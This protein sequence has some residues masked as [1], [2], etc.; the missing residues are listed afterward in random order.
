GD[1]GAQQPYFTVRREG[2]TAARASVAV[3]TDDG[4]ATAPSDYQARASRITFAVGQVARRVA[5]GVK[6][7]LVP[8]QDETFGLRLSSPVG[9][10]IADGEGAATI[11]NDDSPETPSFVI[12]DGWTQEGNLASHPLAITV[13][14]QGNLEGTSTVRVTTADGTA[15]AGRDYV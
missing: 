10:A 3:A 5:V 9:A 1:S 15:V 14:R 2:S 4:I 13:A 12:E 7:D 8:E 6:G 11:L